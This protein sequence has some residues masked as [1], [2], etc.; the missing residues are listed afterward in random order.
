MKT[1]E[2]T[3]LPLDVLEAATYNPRTIS[4]KARKGLAMSL[5]RFGMVQEIVV[6]RRPDGK[7]RIIGGH[8]R[9]EVMRAA[10]E[11][12]VPVTIVE[13]SD[14][15]EHA[16]NLALNSPSVTGTFA[17]DLLTP[18]LQRLAIDDA[19]LFADLNLED[20]LKPLETPAPDADPMMGALEF[21]IVITCVDENQQTDLLTRFEREGIEC[22]GQMI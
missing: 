14:S 5:K 21:R 4:P 8:Q 9:A 13:I 22:K 10:N 20:L 1:P 15:D 2:R 12:Q 3:T 16:L 18:I 17:D 11:T 19:V 6:N 7:F